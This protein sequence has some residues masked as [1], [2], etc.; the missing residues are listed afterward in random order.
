VTFTSERV[1]QIRHKDDIKLWKKNDKSAIM[2][3]YENKIIARLDSLENLA[4]KN[5]PLKC[6]FSL[7]LRINH[8]F[9]VIF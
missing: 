3:Q 2:V 8:F 5:L 1:T 9:S 6:I 4:Y 7:I